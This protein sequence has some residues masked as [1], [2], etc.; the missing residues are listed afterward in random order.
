M[1][2]AAAV[3]VAAALFLPAAQ[4]AERKTVS[5]VLGLD[6]AR[7]G[8]HRLAWFEPGSLTMLHG[9][10]APLGRYTGSWSFSAD[11]SVLAIAAAQ[12]TGYQQQADYKLRFVNARSMRVLGDLN[13]GSPQFSSVT[14]LRPDR[15][16]AVV[17]GDSRLIAVV[18]PQR[19]ALVRQVAL[20]RRPEA[21]A[22]IADSLVLL[23]GNEGSFAPAVLAI[24][25]AE[26]SLRTVTLDRISIGTV[27]DPLTPSFQ[28]R[29]PGLAFDPATRRA[30]VVGAD[31]TVAEVDL[32]TLDVAY[33]GGSARSLAK[34]STGPIRSAVWLGNGLLAVTGTVYSGDAT[35]GQPLGLR[36]IDTRTWRTQLVDPNVGSIG[37]PAANG[38]FFARGSTPSQD[39]DVY[40]MD[41]TLVYHLDLADDEWLSAYGPYG[42]VCSSKDR[43]LRILDVRSGEQAVQLR[44]ERPFCPALLYGQGANW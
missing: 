32:E 28:V 41:G 40:G 27:S 16:L 35:K 39:V 9:R 43:L 18:D 15:L 1:K 25:D 31:F 19:R 6:V 4:A 7:N 23:L 10:K 11:R 38:V 12:T 42:Y 21:V 3:V 29:R 26:G 36:L 20:S 13:L 34:Y 24:V 17:Y 8:V 44:G 30:F 33:H 2:L 37:R 22:R 5:P 14:W